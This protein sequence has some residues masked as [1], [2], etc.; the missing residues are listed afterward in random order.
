MENLYSLLLVGLNVTKYYN[1]AL[2]LSVETANRRAKILNE[3]TFYLRAQQDLWGMGQNPVHGWTGEP[4]S[5]TVVGRPSKRRRTRVQSLD[6]R[7]YVKLRSD[8]E[9]RGKLLAYYQHLN[10]ILGD[11]EEIVTTVE[12]DD[13]TYEEIVRANKRTIPFLF[14]RGD[15]VILVSP[16]LR[17]A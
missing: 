2:D 13:E 14:V 3:T 4:N 8:R 16:P 7:I 17:T 1:S 9:L 12:I 15:G 5:V 6:E 10:M 11:V